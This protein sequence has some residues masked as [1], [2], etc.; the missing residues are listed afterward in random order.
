[1]SKV[2]DINN[3]KTEFITKKGN[4]FA[5]NDVNLHINKEQ[6]VGVVGES[7]CGKSVMA[8]SILNLI[9][10]PGRIHSGKIIYRKDRERIEITNL[11]KMGQEMRSIRGK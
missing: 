5:V 3:L 6:V 7:G 11:N 8:L 1:M 9:D 10:Y 2:L 4:F